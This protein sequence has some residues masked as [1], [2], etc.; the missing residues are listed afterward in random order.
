MA[1]GSFPEG[2]PLIPETIIEE[3]L[4]AKLTFS[5]PAEY[6]FQ[7]SRNSASKPSRSSNGCTACE[8]R[9]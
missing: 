6:S 7:L 8:E 1:M 9:Y 4:A 3:A 5:R 2:D